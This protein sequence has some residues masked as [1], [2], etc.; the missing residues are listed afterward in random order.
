MQG[1]NVSPKEAVPAMVIT[2]SLRYG[3]YIVTV[4]WH[5]VSPNMIHFPYYSDE[6]CD[7]R[8]WKVTLI[9]VYFQSDVG[10]TEE[11]ENIDSINL[12]RLHQLGLH[13]RLA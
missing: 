11:T 6:M 13:C 7:D 1:M 9:R 5:V 8:K 12:R 2:R 3:K 10:S 4:I